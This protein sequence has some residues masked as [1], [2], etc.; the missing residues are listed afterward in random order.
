LTQDLNSPA[1]TGRYFPLA[2]GL[3]KLGHQVTIVA[4]HSN[5]EALEQREVQMDGVN[6]RYLAPMHV[7][8]RGNQKFYYPTYQL[9]P[10]IV[11]ATWALSHAALTTPADIIH[12][13]KPHPMNI[14]AGLLAKTLQG[15]VLVVDFDDLES[16]NNRFSGTWQRVVVSF[17]EKLGLRCANHI[18]THTTVLRNYITELGIPTSNIT[19][20]RHGVDRERFTA[21]SAAQLESLRSRLALTGKKV[22]L[23]VGSMS[24][25]SHAVDT[26]VAAFAC[27]RN[28]VPNAIL[29]LVGGGEDY[30]TI[31]AQVAKLHL[32]DAIH[33]CGRVSAAE[34]ALYY[35]LADVSV[36]PI[37]DNPAGRASISLKMFETWA[38]GAPLVT[39][40]VGDRRDLLGTPPAGLLVPPDD[41]EA[42]ARAI[43]NIIQ[44]PETIALLR[45][46]SQARAG[47]FDWM[48]L[49]QQ[50]AEMY[51][52]LLHST[53]T[54]RG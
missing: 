29:V 3:T 6:V 19:M 8:K 16:A 10:L 2:R 17:F 46:R 33:L 23:F 34:A 22:V 38:A 1:G 27:I 47:D 18:T 30:H 35:H 20:L 21:P 32:G 52:A 11:R 50:I 13:G 9:L 24:L 7:R 26:L 37:R 41:S 48:T 54:G 45:E 51:T 39:V 44:S 28:Q 5:F 49:S 43:I 40:D 42:L 15:R 36:D 12:V 31:Q 25:V 53:A 4:L 14:I